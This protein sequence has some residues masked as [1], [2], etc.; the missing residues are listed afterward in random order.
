MAAIKPQ[1]PR[2]PENSCSGQA[3][4]QTR[5]EWTR[6]PRKRVPIVLAETFPSRKLQRVSATMKQ[7]LARRNC[8][9]WQVRCGGNGRMRELGAS[10]EDGACSPLF[11]Q[12]GECSGEPEDRLLPAR[13][14]RS[15][16]V[17]GC[18]FRIEMGQHVPIQSF[19]IS[20][21]CAA[22]PTRGT[23]SLPAT[24]IGGRDALL[25]VPGVWTFFEKCSGK[26]AAASS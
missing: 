23:A 20:S 13:S 18:G 12:D 8:K 26:E 14:V 6:R 25:R 16:R 22:W 1:H 5:S 17:F 24:M 21:G 7:H 3:E 10:N 19:H 15:A 11:H 2:M 4:M 9:R